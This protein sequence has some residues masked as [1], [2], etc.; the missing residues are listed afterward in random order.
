MKKLER[1]WWKV[2][3]KHFSA[4][5]IVPF[6]PYTQSQH[7][8]SNKLTAQE[9]KQQTFLLFNNKKK[10]KG[11]KCIKIPVNAL[12]HDED[13]LPRS[14]SP[15]LPVNNRFSQQ[16][17]QVLHVWEQRLADIYTVLLWQLAAAAAKCQKQLGRSSYNIIIQMNITG[18]CVTVSSFR[19]WS[20][21][22][23]DSSRII[24]RSGSCL[25]YVVLAWFRLTVVLE[26]SDDGPRES[27]PQHQRGVV[28]FVT[29]NQT[30]LQDTTCTSC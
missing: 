30:A 2:E 25:E 6:L 1:K 18:A 22:L 14:V 5:T 13:F 17:L 7:Q 11:N 20:L 29:D 23:L 27:G 3:H 10:T 15:G 19:Y 24:M 28:Q 9:Q 8:N 16:F 12:D 4:G 21:K 26:D